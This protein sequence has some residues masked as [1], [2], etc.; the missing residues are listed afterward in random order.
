MPRKDQNQSNRSKKRNSKFN[1]GGKSIYS[2]KHNRL[3]EN[4]GPGKNNKT[5]NKK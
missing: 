1:N 4:R 5:K 2:S 3:V